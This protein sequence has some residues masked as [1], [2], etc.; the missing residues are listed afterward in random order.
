MPAHK[1]IQHHLCSELVSVV[2]LTGSRQHAA[3]DGNLEEIGERSAV[4]LLQDVLPKGAR[5]RVRVQGQE[6]TGCVKSCTTDRVLGCFV[7]IELAPE[8]RWTEKWFVPQHLLRLCP[9]LRCFTQEAPKVPEKNRSKGTEFLHSVAQGQA[10][11]S[12]HLSHH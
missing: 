5:V 4:I 9:S 12:N 10:R 2:R 3:L 7:L 8:S 6:L 11:H 1:T